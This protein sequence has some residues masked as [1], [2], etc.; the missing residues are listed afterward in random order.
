MPKVGDTL[1]LSLVVS[2]DAGAVFPRAVLE[3]EAGAALVASPI[4]LAH[5]SNGRYTGQAVMPDVDEVFVNYLVYS[6]AGH[7]TL[8]P[9]F[10]QAQDRFKKDLLNLS[11]IQDDILGIGQDADLI[12]ELTGEETLTTQLLDEESLTVELTDC[13][14]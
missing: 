11:D 14:A 12:A 5:V 13:G 8:D 10:D 6:D 1:Y 4:D 2:G 9:L 3:D 7:T